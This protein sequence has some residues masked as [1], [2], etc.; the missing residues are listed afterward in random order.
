M[1][2]EL[3][4]PLW[5]FPFDGMDVGDSFFVPTLQPAP[6]LYVIDTG[7]KRAGVKIRAYIS[8]KDGVLGVRAWR[9][10]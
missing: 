10:G 2:N 6:M 5:I 3:T 8:S 1:L 7:A 9:T 4:E